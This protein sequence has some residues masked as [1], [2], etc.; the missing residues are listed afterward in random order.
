MKTGLSQKVFETEWFSIDA[1]G[2]GDEKPYY[3]LS[4]SDSVEIMAVTEDGRI[5][6]VRQ[7]RPPVGDYSL[8]FPSGYIDPEETPEEA[9]T[10][11]LREETGYECKNIKRL[12]AYKIVPSR[13]N[14]DLHFFYGEGARLVEEK[15]GS[16]EGVDVLLVTKEEFR[17]L[18]AGGR[19]KEV[20]ALAIYFLGCFHGHMKEI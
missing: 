19:L 4:C 11:E 1:V 13:V 9:I 16:Q 20:A 15:A 6:L 10:R 12:G 2:Y 8:E 18:V 5:I 3:M 14:N 7:Y 17:E